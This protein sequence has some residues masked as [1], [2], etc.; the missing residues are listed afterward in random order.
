[1]FIIEIINLYQ[2][3]GNRKQR[4]SAITINKRQTLASSAQKSGNWRLGS[5]SKGTVTPEAVVWR[6]SVKEVVLEISQNVDC[7]F[8]EIPKNTFFTEHLRWVLL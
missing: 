3:S 6:C 1:M 7:E 2:L 5:Y 4:K 8:C